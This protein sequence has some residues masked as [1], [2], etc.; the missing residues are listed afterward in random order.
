MIKINGLEVVKDLE[1]PDH[2]TYSRKDIDSILN[3]ADVMK[4]EIITTEKDF[5]RIRIFKQNKIKIMKSEL[6]MLDENK[7]INFLI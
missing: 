5:Q 1:F 3:K 4:C 6:T 7:L 2:Y